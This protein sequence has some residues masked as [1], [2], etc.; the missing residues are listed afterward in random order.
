MA[1]PNDP[2]GPRTAV[3][4]RN[5]IGLH[6]ARPLRVDRA[7]GEQQVRRALDGLAGHVVAVGEELRWSWFPERVLPEG[8]T[9]P[10]GGDLETFWDATAFT[11]DLLFTDG[12]RL[13]DAGVTDQYGIAPNPHAQDDARTAWVDQWNLRRVDLT[14][15]AGRTVERAEAI[16]GRIGEHSA[17]TLPGLVGWLDDLAIEVH[18]RP[19]STP[20]EYVD[21][22]RGS[23]SSGRFSRGNTAPLV[24]VPHGGVFALPM[25]DAGSNRWPYSW[26]E[27]G[28]D[29]DVR[30]TI[31]AFATSHLPS[32]WM[33]D[34]GVFQL[35]P[36]PS[37]APPTDRVARGLAFDHDDEDAGPHRYRVALEHGLVAELTAADFALGLR[38]T[39]PNDEGSLILDHHGSVSDVVV[40][41]DGDVTVVEAVLDDRPGTPQHHLHLRVPGVLADH[42]RVAADRLTGFLRLDTR[43]PVE[44]GLGISTVSVADA[45]ANLMAAGTFDAMVGEATRRW[46]Q[47]LDTVRVDGATQD[48][49]RTLFGGLYRLFLYPNR[50]GERALTGTPHY[51]SPYGGVLEHPIRDTPGPEVV[52]AELTT[53]HGFWDTYRTAWPLLAL[54][55][56]DTAGP[57]AQGFV[58]HFHDGGWTPR[59]SAPGAEDCM[60]GTT[61]DTVFADLLVKGIGGIDADAAYAS[62]VRNA[63]VPARDHRVGRK[64]LHPGIFRGYVDTDTPEG[65]SWTLD[66]AINDWSV[67]VMAGLLADRTTDDA[68]RDRYRAE[69]EWFARRSLL[70]RSV[71]DPVTGF[72]RGR[73]PDGSWRGERT[74]AGFDPD[75][76]GHDYTETNA[77]GTMFTAPHDGAGLVALHQAGRGFDIALQEFSAATETGAS[78]VAGSYGGVIH[79]MTEARD[80]RM[81]MLGLSN[82]PAHHIP[83]VP[84]FAGRHDDAHRVVRECVTRLFVGSD[85]GQGYPGDEDNGEMS[86]WWVW[87]AI[88]LYPLSPA[89]GSYVLVPPLFD[90]TELP[91]SGTVIELAGTSRGPYL[92]SV[93]IDGEPW[94]SIAVPHS[95]IAGGAHLVLTLSDEPTG[96]GADSRPVSAS[97]LHG[98]AD[99]PADVLPSGASPL[100]DDAAATVVRL[101]AGEQLTLD[102]PPTD[103]SLYTVTVDAPGEHRWQLE[104][105]APDGTEIHQQ[106]RCEMFDQPRQTRVFRVSDAPLPAATGLRLTAT[107]DLALRQLELIARGKRT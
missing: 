75:V 41:R 7:A 42:T 89:T 45:A 63:T 107:D 1:H 24:A 20:L 91:T 8:V 32:P 11:V 104:L 21:I 95:V 46:E 84:M 105:L 80:I 94:H 13:S 67:S 82:Q 65:M 6:G 99:T 50:A 81:G 30:P 40:R 33:S 49:R 74:A 86:A 76:W 69:Q 59:W 26:A 90:R 103:A 29:G 18:R 52:E 77:W 14:P 73:G 47:V 102:L 101:A 79:E 54:L 93:T 53:T 100:T 92:R 22:R 15:V 51:R 23:H 19:P 9:E 5:G 27:H 64:G 78:A 70:Y 61:S 39:A 87:S 71:F 16:L 83:F 85:L 38:F 2:S 68:A 3:A 60:T 31:Q 48:Q 44:V 37:P 97:E 34:R 55:T 17:A 88:G 57:L 36:H 72:F 66:A 106:T 56:P 25:T 98:Y 43:H 35:M 28:R 10:T 96:W 4:A 12:S 62:A 58:Q